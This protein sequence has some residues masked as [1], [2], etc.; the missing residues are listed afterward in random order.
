MEIS[1][2]IKRTFYCFEDFTEPL[3]FSAQVKTLTEESMGIKIS[4]IKFL[5]SI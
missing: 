1:A 3:A 5:Y 4:C 2:S